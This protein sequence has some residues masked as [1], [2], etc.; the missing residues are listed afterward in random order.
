M[1]A[2]AALVSGALLIPSAAHAAAPWSDPVAVPGSVGTGGGPARVLLT[3]TR[4]GAVAFNA[5][6]S[7]PGVALERSVLGAGFA[8][9]P[10][11]QWPGATDFDSGFG[12]F[13]AADRIIYAGSNGHGRVRLAVAPGP[14]SAWREELR[15]PRTGGARVATAAAAHGGAAAVFSTFG[16]GSIGSVYLVRQTGT[17]PLGPTQM[18]SGRGHIRAVGV[19]VN[20]SGDALAAWDRNGTIEARFWI[21]RSK[22]L[23][24]VQKLGTTGAASHIAVALGTGRRAIVAWDDQ[25]VSEGGAAKGK[26]M[27]TARSAS[28]GFLPAKQLDAFGVNQIAGGIGIRAAYTGDGRGLIAFSGNAAVR[29]ARVDG[30]AIGTPQD[31]A[32]VA[33]GTGQFGLSEIATSPTSDRAVVTWLAPVGERE[34]VQAAVWPAGGHAFGPVEYVSGTVRFVTQPSVAFDSATDAIAIAWSA[35]ATSAGAPA[36]VDVAHRPAP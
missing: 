32:P 3:R 25:R 6:G 10:L 13:A 12:S 15:G 22:R 34:Q 29:A 21:A 19:A 7:F 23:T 18:L 5:P 16:A 26:V 35:P 2:A 24:A 33:A 14:A 9:E 36:E 30:R 20:A 31:L 11:S 17:Q 4:G 1:F 8:P 27:A 28:R